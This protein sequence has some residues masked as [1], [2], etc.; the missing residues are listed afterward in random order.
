[1]TQ[2]NLANAYLNRIRGEKAENLEKAI[3]FSE[4]ALT[5]TPAMP[6]QKTGQ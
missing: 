2:I 6:F 5:F 3:T 4:K 1:M